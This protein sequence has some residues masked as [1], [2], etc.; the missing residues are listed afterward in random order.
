MSVQPPKG[1]D[2]IIAPGSQAWREALRRWESLSERYG[3]PLVSLPVFEATDLFER[4]VGETTEVV[5]K[6]MYTFVDQSNRSM[7][8]RPEGTAGVVRAF[9]NS[10]AQGVWKAAYSG[11]FFRYERPQAGR[12]RQFWQVGAEYLDTPSPVAD[13][14]IV[15]LGYRYITSLG[16]DQVDLL[17]NSIG[18]PVCRPAYVEALRIHL[19]S[20][21]GELSPQSVALIERNPLR[22]L[23]SKV[24]RDKLK[25]WLEEAQQLGAGA[26]SAIG[27]QGEKLADRAPGAFDSVMRS[28][29]SVSNQRSSPCAGPSCVAMASQLACS[30]GAGKS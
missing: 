13:A 15:E 2:D 30:A 11:P 7:T 28:V 16:L 23:D 8:L 17:I 10:G 20:H 27:T 4:G 1:T 29:M 12:R 26:V 22:V 24:D 9:L 3:Y 14:E 19:R 25:G 21:A 18:D 6:Q 5:I